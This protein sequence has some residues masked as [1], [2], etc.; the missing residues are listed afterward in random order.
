MN[1]TNTEIGDARVAEGLSLVA[2]DGTRPLP[3]LTDAVNAACAA[4]EDQRERTVLVVR[5]DPTP[6]GFRAWPGRVGIQEVNRWERAVR[7]LEGV[8]A[9]TIA[10]ARG[11]CG[12]PALDLLLAADY[13]IATDDL[14]L[15][16]PVNDGHFWPGMSVYRLVRHLGVAR[17]RQL[18]L[19]GVDI[20]LRQATELGLIDQVSAD[21]PE[22][23]HT[24]A[25][26]MD[27]VSDQELA[28]RR[29]LVLEAASA[30]FDDA[31][32]VH[33]AAC[34]R[35]LRRLRDAAAE[36]ADPAGTSGS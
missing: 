27:R 35:E 11:T 20:P 24:T 23:V 34:D 28:V 1:V 31:L 8:A 26:L 5:L 33:L 10:T 25:A 19:W 30:E 3:E 6:A 7:R 13:R 17:A 2:I 32:G 21:I 18:V 9:A 15:M 22:A 36:T 12:G 29:N 14:L 16:L 4:V